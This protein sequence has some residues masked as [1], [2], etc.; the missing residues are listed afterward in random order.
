MLITPLV[1]NTLPSYLETVT[2]PSLRQAATKRSP[3]GSSQASQFEPKLHSPHSRCRDT[4]TSR[5]LPFYPITLIQ[6]QACRIHQTFDWVQRWHPHSCVP[7]WISEQ[8]GVTSV[9][10]PQKLPAWPLPGTWAGE[11]PATEGFSTE[12][13]WGV[14]GRTSTFGLWVGAART[15]HNHLFLLILCC[16]KGM[17]EEEILNTK[18][19]VG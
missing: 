18:S 6:R 16:L 4:Q 11:E 17:R 14:P 8:R 3:Q 7:P 10:C 13:S 5:T 1:L 19:P 9:T 15:T 12:L 2:Q